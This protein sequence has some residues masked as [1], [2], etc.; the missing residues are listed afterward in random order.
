MFQKKLLYID[1]ILKALM[2]ELM[3]ETTN[4]LGR[5]VPKKSN[6]DALFN[7]FLQKCV[8]FPRP[9]SESCWGYS[10][11]P[12][13]LVRR[14]ITSCITSNSHNHRLP[15]IFFPATFQTI[16]PAFTTLLYSTT[17]NNHFKWCELFSR[18]NL[19]KFLKC[20]L[21]ISYLSRLGLQSRANL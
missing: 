20:H 17:L 18:E 13:I 14:W 7:S 6:C 10:Q 2:G 8:F 1:W 3:G 12:L 11:Y 15:N 5:R 16:C 4:F 9:S 19:Q 21:I